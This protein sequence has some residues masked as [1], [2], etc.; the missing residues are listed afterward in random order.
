M[1]Q[2]AQQTIILAEDSP[3]QALVVKHALERNG[4]RVLAAANGEAALKLVREQRPSLV[5]S[6]LVMPKMDGYGLC[7]AIKADPDL[8]AIPVLLLTAL[9]NPVEVLSAIQHGAD[10]F[11][12]KPCPDEFLVQRV[13]ALLDPGSGLQETFLPDGRAEF[14]YANRRFVFKPDLRRILSLLLSTYETAFQKNVESNQANESL[15]K[16]QQALKALSITDELTGLLNRRGFLVQAS[17]QFNLVERLR[18]NLVLLYLDLD[19]LK[20]INDQYGHSEGDRALKDFAAVLKQ[21]FRTTDIVGRLGGDEFAVICMET[22]PENGG[23]I[24]ARF[25]RNLDAFREQNPRP[26]LL[27]AS[28]GTAIIGADRSVTLEK[29]LEEADKRMY[30]NKAKK[31]A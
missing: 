20:A 28:V 12:T 11:L 31:R 22:A 13:R 17:M 19:G 29:L 3:T 30:E 27:E 26:Y 10:G 16:T 18:L 9:A 5:I 6:D 1:N 24:L 23:E 25:G 4:F 2:P 21:T 8:A 15:V 14:Q 7:Q